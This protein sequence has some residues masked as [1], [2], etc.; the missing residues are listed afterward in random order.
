MESLFYKYFILSLA[1]IQ[2]AVGLAE[3]IAPAWMYRCWK[4]LISSRFFFIH[5]FL[6]IVV[7]FPLT[8]YKGEFS[9]LLFYIGIFIVLAGPFV[10]IY[11]DKLKNAFYEAEIEIKPESLIKFIYFESFM[12]IGFSLIL[13][14][15]YYNTYFIHLN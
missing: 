3:L 2:G 12:R 13:F 9:G 14:F 10:I 5:G 11:P 1:S 15:S 7:G 4:K 8:L 6:L